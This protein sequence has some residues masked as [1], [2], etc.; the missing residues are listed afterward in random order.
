MFGKI[1]SGVK[2]FCGHVV[3]AA[4]KVKALV[5]GAGAAATA[6]LVPELARAEPAAFTITTPDLDMTLLG[7]LATA[8]LGG[9]A[10]MWLLRKV[11]KT[12]N[13]S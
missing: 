9:L 8:I 6:V 2:S 11:I 5:V 7:T 10:A 12:M 13:K 1:V 4:S 3:Q